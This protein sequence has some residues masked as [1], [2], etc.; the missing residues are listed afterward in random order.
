MTWLFPHSSLPISLLL[1][2]HKTCLFPRHILL[3]TKGSIHICEMSSSSLYY[4]HSNYLVF[5]YQ[6]GTYA[7]NIRVTIARLHILKAVNSYIIKVDP[8][9]TLFP[10]SRLQH[11]KMQMTLQV[12]R[13]LL[14]L[15][16]RAVSGTSWIISKG[17]MP[18]NHAWN[19][20]SDVKQQFL[21]Q[22]RKD[23]HTKPCWAF[24]V[25]DVPALP[26]TVWGGEK[27]YR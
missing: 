19:S 23:S 22:E 5:L 18:S 4:Y 20:P 14:P 25:S 9:M 24:S 27:S 15:P 12:Y 7:E 6:V 26:R 21:Q 8:A 10:F 17:H 16:R 3:F 1:V 2:Q 13:F 11:Q